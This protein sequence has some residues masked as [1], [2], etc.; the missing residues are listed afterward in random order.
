L[1]DVRDTPNYNIS[2]FSVISAGMSSFIVPDGLN[3]P[4]AKRFHRY[5]LVY[6]FNVTRDRSVDGGF[7]AGK[8][9]VPSVQ[10]SI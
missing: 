1:S 10:V 4:R 3:I 8:R 5:E 9:A 6:K 7:L 2:D